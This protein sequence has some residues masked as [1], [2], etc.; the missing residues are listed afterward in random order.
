M[1]FT[2]LSINKIQLAE[3]ASYAPVNQQD[4]AGRYCDCLWAHV[5]HHCRTRLTP[6]RTLHSNKF[7]VVTNFQFWKLEIVD[8]ELFLRESWRFTIW[9]QALSFK[10]LKLCFLQEFYPSISS[11]CIHDS[12]DAHASLSIF[13]HHRHCF[14]LYFRHSLEN[15]KLIQD[16]NVSNSTVTYISLLVFQ[17]FCIV[18]D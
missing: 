17:R 7:A 3:G 14:C 12:Y 16:E 11:Q 4:S 10:V 5:C 2:R 8:G 1:L 15:T 18:I 9:L 6:R 13:Q